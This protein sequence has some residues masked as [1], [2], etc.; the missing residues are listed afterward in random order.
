MK[1]D[2]RGKRFTLKNYK[3]QI[4]FSRVHACVDVAD[5]LASFELSHFGRLFT[6]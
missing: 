3:D 1:N 5:T 2:K 4:F 6:M